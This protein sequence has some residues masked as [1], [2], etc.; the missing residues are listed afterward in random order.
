MLIYARS[1]DIDA[2]RPPS[3]DPVHTVRRVFCEQ[4]TLPHKTFALAAPNCLEHLFFQKPAFF[5][6]SLSSHRG[7]QTTLS[8]GAHGHPITCPCLTDSLLRA[9]PQLKSPCCLPPC[10]QLPV[11]R[12]GLVAVSPGSSTQEMNLNISWMRGK[13]PTAEQRM[14]QRDPG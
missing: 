12:T 13:H 3:L 9:Y 5:L 10:A 1:L 11:G 8:H 6:I 2:P 4:Q 7:F 14:K